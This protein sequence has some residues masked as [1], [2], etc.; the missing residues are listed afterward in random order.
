MAS[1]L[2]VDQINNAAGTSAITIDSNG[3]TLMPGHIIKQ[4][5][6]DATP[7]STVIASSSTFVEA[8][9]ATYTPQT[10][11]ST[12][13][14]DISFY[15]RSYRTGGNDGRMKYQVNVNGTKEYAVIELNAYDFGGGGPW[16]KGVQHSTIQVNNVTGS[17]ISITVDIATSGGT[18][19]SVYSAS[20][21]EG[22]ATIK[23]TEI[24]Q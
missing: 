6:V 4:T 15:Q 23:F 14:V 7:A 22:R 17:T 19:V 2:N 8:I 16:F 11:T 3:N 9:S 20:S 12:V 1:I 10:T 18:G 24:A 21:E 5:L 13:I